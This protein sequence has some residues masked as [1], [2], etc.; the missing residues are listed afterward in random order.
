MSSS[1]KKEGILTEVL[2]IQPKRPESRKYIWIKNI[3]INI[4]RFRC[5]HS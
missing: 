5:I 4:L 1:S 2:S 3:F